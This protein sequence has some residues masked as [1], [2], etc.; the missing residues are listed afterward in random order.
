MSLRC[1]TCNHLNAERQDHPSD[2]SIYCE[3]CGT[4]LSAPTPT[5][6]TPKSP[7]RGWPSQAR[8]AQQRYGAAPLT[9][10]RDALFDKPGSHLKDQH[11]FG[12]ATAA[13]PTRD[14]FKPDPATLPDDPFDRSIPLLSQ[15]PQFD[16]DKPP[17][18]TRNAHQKH[19]HSRP[20]GPTPARRRDR[21]NEAA[22]SRAADGI[23]GAGMPTPSRPPAMSRGP[24]PIPETNA[25]PAFKP[26]YVG[27]P[28]APRKSPG[29]LMA[30]LLFCILTCAA[31]GVAGILFED[32][33]ASVTSHDLWQ[34]LDQTSDDLQRA[35]SDLT[36]SDAPNPDDPPAPAKETIGEPREVG[37]Y[38]ERIHTRPDGS[39]VRVWTPRELETDNPTGKGA[40]KPQASR[41]KRKTS[42]QARRPKGPAAHNFSLRDDQGRTI[43]LDD[44]RGKVVV[45][46]FYANW[47]PPCRAEIPDFARFAKAHRD[48]AVY[49]ILM[50]SGPFTQ[51]ARK[52]R[53]LG[54]TYPILNGTPA[55]GSRYN[56]TAFPT[57]VV[58][59][60]SGRQVQNIKG[61]LNYKRLQSLV[62]DA[63]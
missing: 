1:P 21:F 12:G 57:T 36:G 32:Q 39:K 41:V 9:S 5:A 52:S 58:I 56:V 50:K 6:Q 34:Q 45:L 37:K 63:R 23:P 4:E 59:D 35:A 53:D 14:P 38:I 28:G 40:G 51:A 20:A 48:V 54:V 10:D 44:Q 62:N 55:V 18:P 16:P 47:C 24:L 25:A 30:F 26:A 17:A 60:A 31:L 13:D 15:G 7:K 46:N 19:A 61:G 11:D 22:L 33:I 42:G 8:R 27:Q 43:H 49:G 3:M 29:A 2:S